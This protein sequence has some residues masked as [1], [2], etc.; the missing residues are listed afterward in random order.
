MHYRETNFLSKKT[1][2]SLPPTKFSLSPQKS[3]DK[4]ISEFVDFENEDEWRGAGRTA[5]A[6]GDNLLMKMPLGACC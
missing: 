5:I 3:C 6:V 2:L 1:V 4:L